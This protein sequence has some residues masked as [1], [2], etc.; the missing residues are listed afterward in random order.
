MRKIIQALLSLIVIGCFYSA[1]LKAQDSLWLLNGNVLEIKFVNF[2]GIGLNYSEQYRGKTAY[3]SRDFN[4]IFSYKLKGKEETV[5]YKPEEGETKYSVGDM[6]LYM[7]G[8]RQA[9]QYYH[10]RATNYIGLAAGVGVGY[11]LANDESPVLFAMPVV[12]SGIVLA[13]GV[14][15]KKNALNKDLL[16]NGPY[17]EG[18]KKVA[19]GKKVFGALKYNLLGTLAS[20]ALFKALE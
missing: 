13:T 11:L 6:R 3:R 4:T 16:T 7:R 17:R 2:S 10:S 1:E 14:K 18:Y 12:Y 20:F 9:D 19:K 5:I 15:I 8:L